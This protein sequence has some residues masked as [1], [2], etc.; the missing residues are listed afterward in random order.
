MLLTVQFFQSQ[1]F[2]LSYETEYHKPGDQVEA[3]IKSD[4]NYV[5]G[6]LL[7]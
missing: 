3:G 5:S 1:L 6:K 2:C 7:W 4:Y